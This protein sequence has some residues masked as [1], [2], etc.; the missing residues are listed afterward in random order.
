[1]SQGHRKASVCQRPHT[2]RFCS[3]KVDELHVLLSRFRNSPIYAHLVCSIT[4]VN[5]TG[6]G[7]PVNNVSFCVNREECCKTVKI[8]NS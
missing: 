2:S 4:L 8:I 5:V 3:A 6:L 1:M 7:L